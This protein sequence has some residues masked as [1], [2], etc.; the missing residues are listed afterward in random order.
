[1]YSYRVVN[2]NKETVVI[3][4][5]SKSADE[6]G[7][8]MVKVE[9]SGMPLS[10]GVS[11]FQGKGDLWAWDA[12]HVIQ[13][14]CLLT[15]TRC[16]GPFGKLTRI[17]TIAFLIKTQMLM[18]IAFFDSCIN[19]A[20]TPFSA[21]PPAPPLSSYLWEL[22]RILNFSRSP[23]TRTFSLYLSCLF[24]DFSFVSAPCKFRKGI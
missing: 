10:S 17:S 18:G 6:I 9:R 1:M 22:P 24:W 23:L 11:L 4:I 8:E 16:S 15:S 19:F 21:D 14:P 5:Y 12:V 20:W 7:D 3:C 2:T 13:K